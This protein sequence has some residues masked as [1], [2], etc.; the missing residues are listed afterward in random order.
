MRHLLPYIVLLLVGCANRLPYQIPGEPIL[1]HP[2]PQIQKNPA[3][4]ELAAWQFFRGADYVRALK[5]AYR[6]KEMHPDEASPALLIG[7]IYDQGFHRPD[8]ALSAY[9]HI[10]QNTPQYQGVALLQPRL[11]YLFRLAQE[12]VAQISF[13]QP[14]MGPLTGTP[15]AIYPIQSWSQDKDQTAFALGLTDILFADVLDTESQLPSIR[16]HLLAHAFHNVLPH[17]DARGFAQWSGANV[18][19]SGNLIQKQNHVIQIEL[20]LYDNLGNHVQQLPPI[21]G[22]LSNLNQLRDEIWLTLAPVIPFPSPTERPPMPSALALTLHGQG[23]DAYVSG[24]PEHATVYFTGAESLAPNNQRIKQL[25]AWSQA[26]FVGSQIGQDLFTL[27]EKLKFQP[28][29]DEAAIRRV[30]ATQNLLVPASP[31][32]TGIDPLIPFKSPKPET[33]P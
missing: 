24:D 6:A 20:S 10:L 23:L 19:L 13:E 33:T 16:T 32:E 11:P 14:E 2:A 28:N 9:N 26:D 12:R 22:S 30:L 1:E 31:V 8:L 29:P 18:V 5:W 4:Y 7:L 15:L 3:T 21:L 27:Y 17:S 25:K